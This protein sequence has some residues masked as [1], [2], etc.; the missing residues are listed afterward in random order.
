M[1]EEKR[2]IQGYEVK[3][4]IHIGSKEIILAQDLSVDEPYMV[5]N[6]QWDNP[7]GVDIYD[8]AI[9]DSDYL[10]AMSEFLGRVSSEVQH[11]R[12]QRAERGVTSDP[13]AAADCIPGS[14]H[15][16]YENQ[17]V[18]IKPECMVASARTADEQLLLAIYGN[19]CDPD[20]RG[21][22]VFCKNLFTGKTTRW[23]RFDVAGIIQ[24]ERI[25]EWALLKLKQEKRPSVTDQLKTQ[26]K[27][28]PK[29]KKDASHNI[30]R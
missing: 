16:D 29:R 15:A 17:L 5:C 14:K 27:P 3:N 25:P 6:C 12:E 2:I 1:S 19:G 9:A 13:L 11:I 24:P 21:Q 26:Q 7:L 8:K 22:A 28:S 4:A 23:E 30:E 20:A 10:E 18:I